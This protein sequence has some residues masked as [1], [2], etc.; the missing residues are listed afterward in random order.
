[1]IPTDHKTP[2]L[3]KIHDHS[4]TVGIIGLGYV[5]LP[6]AMAF[7]EKGICVLGFDVDP[8]KPAKLARGESYI[9]HLGSDRVSAMAHSGRFDNIKDLRR[10]EIRYGSR[11]LCFAAR[12][13]LSD[14]S[15]Y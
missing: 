3:A 2:L 13:P 15:Y 8:D 5:G 14:I 7:V 10:I 4:V 12:K 9:K 1:M 6:L 11:S